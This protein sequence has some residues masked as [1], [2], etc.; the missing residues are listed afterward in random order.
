MGATGR[1]STG[2]SDHFLDYFAKSDPGSDGHN[3]REAHLFGGE[4]IRRLLTPALESNDYAES[5]WVWKGR[6]PP[7]FTVFGPCHRV[8]A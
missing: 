4:Y 3:F 2:G 1:L 5:M 6:S 7:S 8:V